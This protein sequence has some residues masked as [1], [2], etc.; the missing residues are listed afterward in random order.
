MVWD[1]ER[2]RPPAPAI[3]NDDGAVAAGC[4]AGAGVAGTMAGTALT[5]VITD[6]LRAGI[7]T[8]AVARRGSGGDWTAGDAADDGMIEAAWTAKAMS[9]VACSFL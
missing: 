6:L 9:L 2:H 3:L 4:L 8:M 5:V 7:V 1:T